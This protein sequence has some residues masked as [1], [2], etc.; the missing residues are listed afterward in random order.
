MFKSIQ[1]ALL[2]KTQTMLAT[3]FLTHRQ[4]PQNVVLTVVP[5]QKGDFSG[6][7]TQPTK[8]VLSKAQTLGGNP[9]RV[10]CLAINNVEQVRVGYSN[11]IIKLIGSPKSS[12]YNGVLLYMIHTP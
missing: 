6:L 2:S 8:T 10:L 11:L 5:Q 9:F 1:V 12:S 4:R 7:G 3:T